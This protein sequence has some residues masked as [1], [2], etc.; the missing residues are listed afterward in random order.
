M[1]YLTYFSQIFSSISGLGFIIGAVILYKTGFLEF[2]LN[3]KKNGNGNGNEKQLK[4]LSEKIEAL[5]GNHLHTLEEMLRD[6]KENNNELRRTME[7][8]SRDEIQRL[9]KIIIYLEKK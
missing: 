9:D 4:E 8:H 5:G 3:L 6:M 1:D 7:E 2:I